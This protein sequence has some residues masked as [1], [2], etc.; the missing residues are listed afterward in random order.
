[1][2][3]GIYTPQTNI[4]TST[5]LCTVASRRSFT[6]MTL[7]SPVWRVCFRDTYASEL[8]SLDSRP[9]T[10]VFY[11]IGRDTTG[12]QSWTRSYIVVFRMCGEVVS[13]MCEVVSLNCTRVRV[14]KMSLRA[15]T[16]LMHVKH[17]YARV[18]HGYHSWRAHACVKLRL[19]GTV[20]AISRSHRVRS[21]SN[22][23]GRKPFWAARRE[24]WDRFHAITKMKEGHTQNADQLSVCNSSDLW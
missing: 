15:R 6:N 8:S 17:K 21:H 7:E 5:Q 10:F 18:T 12:Q 1:M 19:D 16:N 11:I 3:N 20:C 2:H 24:V 23:T 9:R 4:R 13:R 22:S 14:S